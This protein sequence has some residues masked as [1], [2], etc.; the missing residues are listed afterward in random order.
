MIFKHF[1]VRCTIRVLLFGATLFVAIYLFSNTSSYVAASIIAIVAGTQLFSLIQFV[2]KTN[3]D[4]DRFLR[5]IR[6]ADFSQSFASEKRGASFEALSRSFSEVMDDFRQARAEKEEHYRYLQTVMQHVGIGL[7]TF[8]GDGSVG[9]INSAAKRL[10]RVNTLKNVQA[11]SALSPNLVD[12]LHRLRAGEK[13]LVKVVDNDEL[14]QLAIYASEF[15][16]RGELFKLISIQDIQSELEE[17]EIEAW[18]KLTR[19]LTHEI[20]NSITPIASLAATANELLEDLNDTQQE[21]DSMRNETIG[22]IHSAVQTVEKRSKSLLSF[23]NAYRVLTRIPKPIFQILPVIDLFESVE[24]LL[25]PQME[26]YGIRFHR[27]IEP[28]KLTL[29]AD[30][31]LVERVLINLTKNAIEAVHERPYPEIHLF[32]G[33]DDRGRT[34]IRVSDNGSGIVPEALDKIFIPFFTTKKEGSG[35]GLSLSREIMRQH[36]GTI[37]AVS[38]PQQSTVFTLRF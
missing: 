2:E 28:D 19:V 11:L 22:D 36:G 34:I 33:I 1:R 32:A 8:K 4:L 21:S 6:Y 12:T 5:S 37:N 13:V 18:Q 17:K 14:L 7:F 29:T 9:L 3:R 15:K 24:G 16:L 30:P 26:A 38:K 20:M 10:L 31:E 35:I 27:D 25:T 23:V